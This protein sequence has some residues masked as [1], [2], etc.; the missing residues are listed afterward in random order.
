MLKP[1]QKRNIS[2]EILS[3]S[4]L[5]IRNTLL[6]F[7]LLSLNPISV[8]SQDNEIEDMTDTVRL[9]LF[10]DCHDCDFAYFR[11]NLPYVDFVRDPKLSDA[12]LLVTEQRTAS[13]GRLY[14]FN[15]IGVGEFSDLNY[16]L[17]SISPQSDTDIETWKRLMQTTQMGLMPFMNRTSESESLEIQYKKDTSETSVHQKIHDNWNYWV[18]RTSLGS[19]IEMEE[20]QDRY[21]VRGSFRVDRIT[22]MF[23]FRSD[24]MYY[25]SLETFQDGDEKIESIREEI[26]SDIE[27]IFSLGP[28]WSLGLFTEIRSSTYQNTDLS[29]RLGPAIEY[30]IFPWDQSDRRVFSFGYHIDAKYFDYHEQTI[31]DLTKEFRTSESLRLSLILRQPWGEVET[32]LEGSHYFHDFSKNRLTLES[33]ISVNVTKGLSIY[34]EIDG[35][36]IHDQLYLPAGDVT[37]EEL[38]LEQR[39]LESDYEFSI[40]FGINFTFGSI[41]NNIVNERL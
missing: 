29:Y 12:H 18:F 19:Y 21:S 31:F 32:E 24:I 23:K 34:T 27:A 20:S 30:N 11:R 36:L 28:R 17:K 7:L 3:A 5:F 14:G 8:F 22:E 10:L 9:K 33:R 6:I 35:G 25:K 13:N 15:F 16:K 38:L 41:Y 40:E 4:K 39:Q 2:S 1:D 26:H 37:I